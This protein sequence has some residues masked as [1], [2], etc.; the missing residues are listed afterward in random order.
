MEKEQ[1]E[2]GW[3]TRAFFPDVTDI[4]NHKES[5]EEA[6]S[7]HFDRAKPLLEG[8][9]ALLMTDDPGA[10]EAT[11]VRQL[12]QA[13][14]DTM[15]MGEDAFDEAYLYN[16]PPFVT[17]DELGKM[18]GNLGQ[19]DVTIRIDREGFVNYKMVRIGRD[20]SVRAKKVNGKKNG[21]KAA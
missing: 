3:T 10:F 1:K 8:A 21:K 16:R 20:L 2:L 15:E 4:K 9:M 13:F 12:L 14:L 5:K 17:L 6:L 7:R 18:L 11:N 19:A